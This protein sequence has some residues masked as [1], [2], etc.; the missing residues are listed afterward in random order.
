MTVLGTKMG[1]V[2]ELPVSLSFVGAAWADAKVLALG[3]G[4]ELATKALSE[5]PL[6]QRAVD[7]VRVRRTRRP[8]RSAASRC[9]AL[10]ADE[11][12]KLAWCVASRG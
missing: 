8:S 2:G 12:A 1:F 7:D 4:L 9:S 10:P 11:M 3:H 5:D 6:L